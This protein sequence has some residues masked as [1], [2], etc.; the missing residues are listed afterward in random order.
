MISRHLFIRN[1]S[2]KILKLNPSNKILT[3]RNGTLQRFK[4]TSSFRCISTLLSHGTWAHHPTMSGNDEFNGIADLNNN[5]S[6][7]TRAM[8]TKTNMTIAKEKATTY[9]NNLSPRE[10]GKLEQN[11]LSAISDKVID[12]VLKTNIRKLGWLQSLKISSSSSAILSD[13]KDEMHPV[14]V[15]LNL[16]TLMH[17]HLEEMKEKVRNVV[18][19][20]ILAS[21]QQKGILDDSEF[22]EIDAQHILEINIDAISSK[23]APFVRNIEEQDDLIKKLGPGLSNVRHFLA[24]YSCKGGVGKSTVAVNLA[25]ELARLGGRVGKLQIQYGQSLVNIILLSAFS[26]STTLF[27]RALYML[28][29]CF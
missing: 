20:E 4:H 13:E 11:I 16:P 2:H 25:Y 28:T 29:S 10:E 23:P 8:T 7:S 14:T 22:S 24:V 19:S 3:N 27:E 6:I 1:A 18:S 5:Q 12:P 9:L 21:M 17:P 26:Q 15:E